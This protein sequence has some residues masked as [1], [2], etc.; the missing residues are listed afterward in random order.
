MRRA[1]LISILLAFTASAQ[2]KPED[3]Y[4]KVDAVMTIEAAT[5]RI[6]LIDDN[7]KE[8]GSVEFGDEVTITIRRMK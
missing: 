6:H 3:Q 2:I 7:G 5:K 1:I 4:K 8:V